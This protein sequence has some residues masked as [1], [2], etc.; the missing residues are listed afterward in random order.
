MYKEAHGEEIPMSIEIQSS[1]IFLSTIQHEIINR[2]S[3]RN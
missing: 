3:S 2:F 1:G